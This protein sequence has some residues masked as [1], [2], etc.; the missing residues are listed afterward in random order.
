MRRVGA[1]VR[2]RDLVG[3]LQHPGPLSWALARPSAR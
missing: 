3:P 1:L 2:T